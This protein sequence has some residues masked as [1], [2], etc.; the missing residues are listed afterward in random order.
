MNKIV[1][2]TSPT[3]PFQK[4]YTFQNG[5]LVEQLGVK[6]DD[7]EEIIDALCAKYDI[8]SIDFS[9]AI[10]YA[11]KV[12]DALQKKNMVDYNNNPVK[13]SYITVKGE[14]TNG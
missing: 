10:T 5:E 3:A 14:K 2:W 11:K 9:G 13:I 6:F 8:S 12:G 7:L 1:I 4:V